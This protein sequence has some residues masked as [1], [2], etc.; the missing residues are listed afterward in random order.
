MALC[1]SDITTSFV[2]MYKLNKLTKQ[3]SLL[4]SRSV[5]L[6][7]PYSAFGV[8]LDVTRD[9]SRFAIRCQD[10]GNN[11]RSL[12]YN[13]N[14]SNTFEFDIA[15]APISPAVDTIGNATQGLFNPKGTEFI[16]TNT[17]LAVFE[18]YVYE[19]V[20]ATWVGKQ[21]ITRSEDIRIGYNGRYIMALNYA[22]AVATDDWA[23]YARKI[24]GIY[25]L[26]QRRDYTAAAVQIY[27]NVTDDDKIMFFNIQAG[28]A[29][30]NYLSPTG[31]SI[32]GTT[33]CTSVQITKPYAIAP[34]SNIGSATSVYTDVFSMNAITVTSDRRLKT[35]ISVISNVAAMDTV[36]ML[37]PVSYH[38][39]A[40]ND[41]T[42]HHGFIAS[43]VSKS[44]TS[45]LKYDELIP[46]LVGAINNMSARLKVLKAAA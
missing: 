42:F 14:T 13:R 40:S 36:R 34:A 33:R 39:R 3:R 11:S 6:D 43:E 46:L 17:Q 21:T 44:N 29:Y 26:T 4:W 5:S 37:N 24:S 15:L 28:N 22:G 38:W 12:I 18:I 45:N 19:L 25:E 20:N 16:V 30:I 23:I 1:S 41:R 32:G 7:S 31:A 2:R 8:L 9:G 10:V 27:A 35:G